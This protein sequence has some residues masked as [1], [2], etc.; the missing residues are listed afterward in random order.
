MILTLEHREPNSH[1]ELVLPLIGR[2]LLEAGWTRASIDRIGVGVGPGSFVGLR[3][4][5]ALAEGLGLGLGCPVVGVPSL[6]AM[7]RA[8]PLEDRRARIAVLDARRAEI[9]FTALSCS[10]QE[11][12]PTSVAGRGELARALEPLGPEAALVGEVATELG[13]QWP[14]LRG[15][16]LDLPHAGW[17]AVLASE[18][19]PASAPPVPLYIRGAGAT[20]PSL[21]QSPLRP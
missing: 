13:L 2:L 4:G 1:A 12:I 10:G 5:I 6:H 11:L 14:I 21:P 20:L 7:A 9:F 3:A 8:V 18:L 16:E 15:P 17:V 19:E